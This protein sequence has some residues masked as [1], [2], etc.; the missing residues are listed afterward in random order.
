MKLSDRLSEPRKRKLCSQWAFAAGAVLCACMPTVAL[1]DEGG[2]SFWLPGLFGS[3]AAAP[4]QPGLSV[5][6]FWY[7]DQLRAGA[8]VTRAREV[9]IGSIPAN[10]RT[11]KLPNA[12]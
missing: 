12:A 2:I 8:N 1:A 4:L 11:E 6:T 3:L 9:T 10:L 5:T 7:N